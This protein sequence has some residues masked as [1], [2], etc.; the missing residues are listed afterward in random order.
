MVYQLVLCLT[1]HSSSGRRRNER[2]TGV[3]VTPKPPDELGMEAL[4]IYCTRATV[5]T[6]LSRCTDVK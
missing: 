2:G 3:L 5:V 1:I 4:G 6:G